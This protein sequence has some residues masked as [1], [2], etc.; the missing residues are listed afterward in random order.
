MPDA[1]HHLAAIMFTDIIGYTT[2]VG[3]DEQKAV[4]VLE[5]NLQIHKRLIKQYHGELIKEIGDGL[6]SSFGSAIDAVNCAVAI[7]QELK[8]DPDFSIRTGIHLGDVMLKDGDVFGDG[9]Y[10]T[11]D[12]VYGAYVACYNWNG[13]PDG[14]LRINDV[15]NLIFSTGMDQFTDTYTFSNGSTLGT[16]FTFNWVNTYGGFGT[17]TLTRQDGRD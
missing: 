6:M 2:L 14:S 17:V 8:D 15:C 5:K 16:S 3:Q 11:S 4:R 13:T 12:F 10:E 9:V 1:I 7:Q